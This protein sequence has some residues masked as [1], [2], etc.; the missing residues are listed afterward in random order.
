MKLLTS[1]MLPL[2]LFACEKKTIRNEIQTPLPR[3]ERDMVD[4]VYST[5]YGDWNVALEFHRDNAGLIAILN[6]V[7]DNLDVTFDVTTE[8]FPFQTSLP[9]YLVLM[10]RDRWVFTPYVNAG[11]TA[12]S[13]LLMEV[14]PYTSN[15]TVWPP[16]GMDNLAQN[17]PIQFF[18][19]NRIQ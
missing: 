3:Y 10:P 13:P 11:L 15:G 8:F 2:V 5:E 18:V 19:F 16:F 17:N 12:Y 4:T 1:I 14:Y 7:E 6:R 9:T